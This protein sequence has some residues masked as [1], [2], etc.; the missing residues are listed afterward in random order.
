M[1][2]KAEENWRNTFYGVAGNRHDATLRLIR[3]LWGRDMI[4][5]FLYFALMAAYPAVLFYWLF[6]KKFAG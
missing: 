5:A 3:E 4:G 1:L 6:V 2:T